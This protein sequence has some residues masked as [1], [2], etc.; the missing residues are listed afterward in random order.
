MARSLAVE[1][2]ARIKG[3]IA[4]SLQS[5]AAMS[6]AKTNEVLPA[7]N[8]QGKLYEAYVLSLIITNLHLQEGFD[9][10]MINSGAFTFKQKGAPINRSYPYFEVRRGSQLEGEIFTDTEFSGLSSMGKAP[11]SGDYHELDIAMFV[12]GQTGRPMMN[13]ILLA[14]ECKATAFEKSTF[15]ELLG[16]RREMAFLSGFRSTFFLK[17]PT[18][19]TPSNPASVHLCYSTD[20]AINKYRLNALYFGILLYHEVM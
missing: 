1:D 16:F 6:P 13:T 12:P 14:A 11:S 2:V 20:K 15:R 18:D 3:K 7:K 8:L 10:R 5:H 9:I 19:Q 17:W 4:Q